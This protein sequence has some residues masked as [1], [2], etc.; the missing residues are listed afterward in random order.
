MINRENIMDQIIKWHMSYCKAFKK[1]VNMSHYGMYLLSFFKD[2]LSILIVLA[3]VGCQTAAQVISSTPKNDIVIPKYFFANELT[4]KTCSLEGVHGYG[5]WGKAH[6]EM[7]LAITHVSK[8]KNPDLQGNNYDHLMEL[9]EYDWNKDHELRSNS[10]YVN[11]EKHSNRLALLHGTIVYSIVNNK[12]EEHGPL[13]AEVMVAWAK[14]GVMANTLTSKEIKKLKD[15]GKA[16]RLCYG[17]GTGDGTKPCISH[18]PHEAQIYGATYM[19]QAY[20][21]KDQ[22]TKE[23]FKIIDEYIDTLYE[24]YVKPL[25]IKAMK[26]DKHTRGFIQLADG[27][28]GVLSYLAWKDK[29]EEVA[30]WIKKGITKA[31][32]VLYR[33]GYIHNNSFRGVRDVWY[34]SQGVNNLLGLYAIAELWGYKQFPKELKQRIDKTV[35]IL[36]LGLTDVKTYRKRKDPSGMQNHTKDKSHSAYHVHQMAIS[37]D[38]L[39]ENYTDRDHT[40]VANDGMWKSKKSAYFVDRNFGFEP[41]CI[42]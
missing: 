14:A 39:I 9:T 38:W 10:I 1:K 32:K 7:D 2:F 17:N 18:R 41:K 37:L 16:D 20:L 4:K 30:K 15:Q 3:L 21:M 13:I 5:S 40:I 12:M 23:Q 33:D 34:H 36:N 8:S 24:K 25:A 11:H 31:D 6:W 29:P 28:I 26:L 19:Q 35:D 42:N 22:F 27:T